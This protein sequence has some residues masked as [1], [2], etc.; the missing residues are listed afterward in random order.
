MSSPTGPAA[1]PTPG[2]TMTE[3]EQTTLLAVLDNTRRYLEFGLGQSTVWACQRSG[4]SS[5]DVVESSAQFAGS[6]YEQSEDIRNH[7][8]LGRLRLHLI[9]IGPTRTWGFPTDESTA[10]RWP[11]YSAVVHAL[12]GDWDTV[13]IDGRFRVACALNVL[14]CVDRGSRIAIHDF[15]NRNHYHILLNYLDVEISVDTLG[16]FRK[17]LHCRDEDLHEVIARYQRIPR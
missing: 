8:A 14:L 10:D 1:Q 15:W 11:D 7:M 5:I 2:S 6:L 16:V 13:L 12:G 9:D 3:P 17:R 4:V